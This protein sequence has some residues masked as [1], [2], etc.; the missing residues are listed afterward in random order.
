CDHTFS[1]MAPALSGSTALGRD[2]GGPTTLVD[3]SDRG[4]SDGPQTPDLMRVSGPTPR[5]AW[6]AS[7]RALGLTTYAAPDRHRQ[8]IRGRWTRAHLEP[9]ARSLDARRSHLAG[10]R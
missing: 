2:G 1:V 10:Q 6:G 5:P 7:P 8:R 3:G 9:A 4:L